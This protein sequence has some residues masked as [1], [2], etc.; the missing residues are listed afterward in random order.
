MA[1]YPDYTWLSGKDAG[2]HQQGFKMAVNIARM[3]NV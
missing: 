3:G 1:N 2:N